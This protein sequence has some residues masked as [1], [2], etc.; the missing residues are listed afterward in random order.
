M[1]PCKQ[2]R[3]SSVATLCTGQEF[4]GTVHHEGPIENPDSQGPAEKCRAS[5][6]QKRAL[7]N[8]PRRSPKTLVNLPDHYLSANLNCVSGFMFCGLPVVLFLHQIQVLCMEEFEWQLKLALMDLA[9][10]A[11]I[12]FVPRWVIRALSLSR[13]MTS[14]APPRWRIC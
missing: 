13:S 11:A 5:F 6:C 9:G 4:C 2:S 10:L 1:N 8:R 7:C 12:F 14:P 3:C